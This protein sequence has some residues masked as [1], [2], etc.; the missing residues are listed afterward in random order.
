[1]KQKIDINTDGWVIGVYYLPMSQFI[2]KGNYWTVTLTL[3]SATVDWTPI[4]N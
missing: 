4:G 3:G 1:M 2:K